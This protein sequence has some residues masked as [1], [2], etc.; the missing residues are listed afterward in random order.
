[1]STA[2]GS[3][4]PDHI[5]LAVVALNRVVTRTQFLFRGASPNDPLG[6]ALQRLKTGIAQAAAAIIGIEQADQA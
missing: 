4:L 6:L 3:L 1:M 5:R 2:S